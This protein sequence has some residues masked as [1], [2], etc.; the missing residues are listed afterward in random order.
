L[1]V[2]FLAARPDLART[3]TDVKLFTSLGCS[4]LAERTI[5]GLLAEGQYR[6]LTQRLRDRVAAATE[7]AL[8]LLERA[9]FSVWAEPRGGM[10]LW[11]ERSGEDPTELARRAAEG[12]IL[13][14]PGHLFRPQLQH[15][16]FSRFNVTAMSDP[17][18]ARFLLDGE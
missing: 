12:G 4:E 8:R 1:R 15:T 14:A 16:S 2:G 18:V 13:L 7:H 9:G 5:H 17:R 10:F 11:A 6:K 3:F